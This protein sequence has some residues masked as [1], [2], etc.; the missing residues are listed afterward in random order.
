[1]DKNEEIKY[2]ELIMSLTQD[3]MLG[4]IDFQH[5]AHVLYMANENVQQLIKN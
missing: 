4:K 1:M 5:Y 2:A 3:Y